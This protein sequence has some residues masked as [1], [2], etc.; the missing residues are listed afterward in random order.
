MAM[1]ARTFKYVGSAVPAANTAAGLLD[2]L[3][4]LCTSATYYDGSART[5]G[6]GVAVTGTQHQVGGITECIDIAP[7][8]NSH[9][10]RY[11]FS[12][13]ASA[14]TPTMVTSPNTDTW[15]TGNVL[16]GLA[17]N[18][19]T[20]NVTGNGW[21]QTLPGSAGSSFTGYIR[22][23][24]CASLTCTKVHLLECADG[25]IVAWQQAANVSFTG[26]GLELDPRVTY[27]TSP[28]SAENTTGGRYLMWNTS[29]SA[30]ASVV[31]NSATGVTIP[32]S[33]SAANTGHCY[34]LS[35]G[36]VSLTSV[37][38]DSTLTNGTTTTSFI[39]NDGDWIPREI[40]I[41]DS[42]NI[43]YGR[44]REIRI[45]PDRKLGD[46]FSV[47]GVVKG[48]GL[49]SHPTSDNDTLWCIA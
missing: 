11:L 24:T 46:T 44:L 23:F 4:T 22:V 36:G 5:P 43:P 21:D 35:V 47:S 10:F 16:L 1:T 18:W 25:I 40:E 29:A 34:A 38:K 19:N 6:A 3:Y 37:M 42:S 7:Y 17:R 15:A 9:N 12:G 45:G 32:F 27:S 39:N 49:S 33:S 8:S 48:Y 41:V 2:A 28:V 26:C 31:F 20:Y 30:A 14:R 13:S